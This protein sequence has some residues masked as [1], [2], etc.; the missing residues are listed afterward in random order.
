MNRYELILYWSVE[1]GAFVVEV[2]EL[3]GCMAH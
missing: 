1:D 2:P 3:S